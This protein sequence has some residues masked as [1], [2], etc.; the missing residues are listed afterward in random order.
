MVKRLYYRFLDWL[1]PEIKLITDKLD[2]NHIVLGRV[3]ELIEQEIS[4][5]EKDMLFYKSVAEQMIME[6][7][8]MAWLKDTNGKYII[9]NDTIK[10]DLLCNCHVEGRDDVLLAKLAQDKYGAVNH[11]FGQLCRNSDKIV[12]DLVHSGKWGEDKNQGRF[13]EY[14]LVKGKMLYLEVNKFPVFVKDELYGIAG[15]GR[16]LTPYIEALNN[17]G[18]DNCGDLPSIFDIFKF[19]ERGK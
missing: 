6:S 12:V 10:E 15:F 8:D 7:P 9:A 18:C 4:L 2:D 11:T 16:D 3:H 14:G 13:Y 17:S 5:I 1:Y 19:D